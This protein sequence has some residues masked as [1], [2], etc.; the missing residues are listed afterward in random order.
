MRRNPNSGFSLI[1]LLIVI[2][3]TLVISAMALP[4]IN[5]TIQGYIVYLKDST[6]TY[7]WA[8]VT[9]TPAGRMKT[10]YYSGT[11]LTTGKWY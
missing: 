9:V 6:R 10:W 3:I 2:A 8:A 5:Y 7:S 11:N 1:E 4:V